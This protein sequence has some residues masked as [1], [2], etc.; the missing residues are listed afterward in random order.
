MI[1]RKSATLP[2]LIDR[3]VLVVAGILALQ[4]VVSL[5]CYAVLQRETLREDHARRVA[6]LL[7][8]SQRTHDLA[9][10][11]GGDAGAL[12]TTTYLEASVLPQPPPIRAANKE[13]QALR[14]AIVRWEPQLG[15]A[16]LSL[17]V[18]P[19]AGGSADVHGAMRLADGQWLRFRSTGQER[20]WPPA[21]RIALFTAIVAVL[22]FTAAFAVLRHL[23]KPLRRLTAAASALG[24]RPHVSVA[25]E[26]PAEVRELG[27][28]FNEMQHRITDLIDDQRRTMQA[29]SHD[30]RTPLA[31]LR[32]AA[33]FVKPHDARK[34]VVDNV[35]ELDGLLSSLNAYLLAQHQAS[36]LED[37][38]LP[39]LIREVLAPWGPAAAY[40]GPAMLNAPAYRTALREALARLVENAVRHGGG[41]EVALVTGPD[42]GVRIVV[43]DHGPGMAPEDLA[44]VFEPFFRADQARARNTAG[45]GLGVPTATRLLRRFGGDLDIENAPDGGLMVSIKP[46]L[47]A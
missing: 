21:G 11:S 12:M 33:E 15:R 29:I 25:V 30:M 9:K 2:G 1:F 39:A 24:R 45:F 18:L 32:L 23:G 7:V 34:L 19:G 35:V 3:S 10:M 42:Q 38:D 46:P 31:R 14:R 40:R 16:D 44:H 41:A 28:A 17:W 13:A 22:S 20:F 27:Q 37:T 47:A 4:L 5:A 26:G 36:E 43:R 8:V 6:E